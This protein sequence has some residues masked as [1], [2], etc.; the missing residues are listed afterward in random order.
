MVLNLSSLEAHFHC[1]KK[2][3][4][5]KTFNK[6]FEYHEMFFFIDINNTVKLTRT[7]LIFVSIYQLVKLHC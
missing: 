3:S 2:Y 4:A 6:S 1:Q 7:K 5:H